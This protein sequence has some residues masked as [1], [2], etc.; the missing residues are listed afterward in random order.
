MIG[1]VA[2]MPTP[3]EIGEERLLWVIPH[4]RALDGACLLHAALQ[5]STM[6]SDV[7]LVW[8]APW[9]TEQRNSS[10]TQTSTKQV[11]AVIQ[12]AHVDRFVRSPMESLTNIYPCLMMMLQRQRGN[13]FLRQ[14]L[15]WRIISRP[16]L[17]PQCIM[18]SKN[19]QMQTVCL[20][21]QT[22]ARVKVGRSNV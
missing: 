6:V 14:N 12:N 17:L 3:T 20:A 9:H 1:K 19:R 4:I 15:S 10:I 8:V 5:S 2:C 16:M 11:L 13:E 7:S 18:F 21:T 22:A